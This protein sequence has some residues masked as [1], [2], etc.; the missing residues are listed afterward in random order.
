MKL[1]SNT[2]IMDAYNAN[3]S[4]M[5]VAIENFASMAGENKVLVLGAMAE[6]GE[7]SIKEHKEIIALI[8]RYNWKSVALTGGDF[9]KVDHPYLSFSSSDEAAQ[10]F[11]SQ[12]FQ[13]T[14]FLI[15][16][17]RSAKMEQVIKS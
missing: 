4:S 14:I 1:G 5:K 16:G 15:K 6:L 10:W 3:P 7:E 2:I 9:L 17:S 13:D 8:N 11:R 12:H